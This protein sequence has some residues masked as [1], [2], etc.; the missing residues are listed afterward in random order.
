MFLIKTPRL[1]L[2]IILMYSVLDFGTVRFNISGTSTVQYFHPRI[3]V[4]DT[5]KN[6]SNIPR[7]VGAGSSWGDVITA[8]GT[9]YTTKITDEWL[10][11][12]GNVF[13]IAAPIEFGDNTTLT[14]FD[15][16]GVFVFWPD[17]N[18]ATDPR[19]HVT[20]QAFR[21]YANLR[22]NVSDTINLSGSYNCGDS[23]PPWDFN[24]SNLSVITLSGV[25]FTRIGRFDLG[26]SVIGNG[27][28]DDCKIVYINNSSTNINGSSFKKS[29][30]KSSTKIRTMT[31]SLPTV[32]DLCNISRGSGDP[33][34]LANIGSPTNTG[35]KSA[36]SL[37][38]TGNAIEFDNN[39]V[40]SVKGY[41]K[42]FENGQSPVYNVNVDTKVLLWHSQFNAP[43]RIQADTLAQGGTRMRIY[44]GTGAPPSNYKEWYI[45]GNDTPFAECIKGQYP[46]IIDLNDLSNNNT[47]GTFDNTNV[48]SFAYLTKRLDMAGTSTSWNY[49]GKLYVLDTTKSSANTPTF[50]GTSSFSDA[51]TLIQGTDYTNKL[52]NWVRKTGSVIFID[53][54]F[55]IGDNSSSTQFND[56]GQTIISPVSNDAND[57]RVRVTN[58]AFRTYL[59]LRNNAVDT[60]TIS[61]KWIWQTRAAFDWDQNDSAVV[62]FSNPTF[63]GMGTF[64]LGSSITGSGTWD[65]VDPVIF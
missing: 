27:N 30:R 61:G 34:W 32:K 35:T 3:F 56:N 54:G 52:G 17:S 1:A 8:M 6:A 14:S 36:G 22:S 15:D 18:T 20:D 43:N 19:I 38:I 11:Q 51:V 44:S 40:G 7:F 28:F 50:I 57:P 59:N 64:T 62:T 55:R 48:T 42:E 47:V 29:T 10:K 63:N 41:A 2:M 58:Q 53:M 39:T 21:V 23:Y 31:F 5:T 60:A 25:N 12:E 65:N 13:S 24:L 37:P 26:S 33:K 4:F 9:T 46:I 49:Q 16:N 45:G